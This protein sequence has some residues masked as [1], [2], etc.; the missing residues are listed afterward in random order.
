MN[1][2]YN[3]F[4][5]K[6]LFILF[7]FSCEFN[8]QKVPNIDALKK[9]TNSIINQ[10]PK[11]S[12]D[13]AINSKV[14]KNLE[15]KMID[16]QKDKPNSDTP[17]LHQSSSD[18]IHKAES[19]KKPNEEQLPDQ[20][21]KS[22]K[23]SNKDYNTQSGSLPNKQV[24]LDEK[25]KAIPPSKNSILTLSTPIV[26]SIP[27]PEE[28][29]Q[30]KQSNPELKI[31]VDNQE[32]FKKYR[33]QDTHDANA[34]GAMMYEVSLGL[35]NGD[36]TNNNSDY[37]F[38]NNWKLFFAKLNN[39]ALFV[40]TNNSYWGTSF[41]IGHNNY[42]KDGPQGIGLD[43]EQK[44]IPKFKNAM[45]NG[46]ETF[47]ATTYD[48]MENDI[49]I[50]VNKSDS[51]DYVFLKF[52]VITNSVKNSSD[53]DNENEEEFD[54]FNKTKSLLLEKSFAVKKSDFNTFINI[55]E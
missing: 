54:S 29:Q 26:K 7:F 13:P 15:I 48:D 22:T 39:G 5:S 49:N 38:N 47:E 30:Q 28:S 10:S 36:I 50:K 24:E 2:Y 35:K 51:S 8:T 33:I 41:R 1:H 53:I 23:N 32:P 18:Q 37:N 55:I 42:I 11:P 20:N 43:L 12:Y 14:Q 40:I 45:T 31:P 19:T 52:E 44:Y 46:N 3:A 16:E 21:L 4:T 27:K 25:S 6:F 34:N 9:V 17:Q